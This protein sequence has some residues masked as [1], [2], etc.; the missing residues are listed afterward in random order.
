MQAMDAADVAAGRSSSPTSSAANGVLEALLVDLGSQIQRGSAVSSEMAEALRFCPTGIPALDADLGGG[1]PAGRLCEICGAPSSGRTSLALSLLAE[2]LERGVLAA[3]IDLADAFDPA[4]AIAAGGDLE[5]LLWVRA[6]SEDEALRSSERLLQTEGFEL[7]ILDLATASGAVPRTPKRDGRR[8]S[9]DRTREQKR[10]R[11]RGAGI[12]DVSW[13]RMARLAASTR[14]TLVAL[15]NDS[16]TGSRAE[17]V[18]EMRARQAHFLEPP[19]LLDTLETA[20]IPK[21]HRSRP[22]GRA[23]PLFI[24]VEPI[25]AE[26]VDTEPIDTEPTDSERR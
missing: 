20:A 11:P 24:D 6:R 16:M 25:D 2:T 15:S 5:R 13:L 19:S 4:S 21:R 12:R 14:T 1:F 3:W 26:P 23:T 10:D 9:P 8:R 7:I 17:L 18:L 22:I